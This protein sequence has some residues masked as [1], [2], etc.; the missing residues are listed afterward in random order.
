VRRGFKEKKEKNNQEK[1]G[2]EGDQKKKAG[3]KAFWS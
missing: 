3:K 2:K 1:A